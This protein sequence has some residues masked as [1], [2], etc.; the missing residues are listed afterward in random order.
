MTSECDLLER[1]INLKAR[2]GSLPQTG[3]RAY[4][5]TEC[6]DDDRLAEHEMAKAIK[7]ECVSLGLP[8]EHVSLSLKVKLGGI[9]Y[10]IL[11]LDYQQIEA[12]KACTRAIKAMIDDDSEGVM[13][14]IIND[15][16]NRTEL[17]GLMRVTLYAMLRRS[18]PQPVKGGSHG[19]E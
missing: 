9:L 8:I 5:L 17:F 19:Y 10:N 3:S 14:S 18:E 4:G 11:S 15:K 6:D 16:P 1:L 7:D 2:I 12:W 13:H